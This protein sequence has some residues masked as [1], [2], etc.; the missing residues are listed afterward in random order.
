MEQRGHV[1]LQLHL[2]YQQ[3]HCLLRCDLYKRFYGSHYQATEDLVKYGDKEWIGGLAQY[4]SISKA[5]PMETT[6]PA[7][8]DIWWC[9][10]KYFVLPFPT[11]AVLIL[12]NVDFTQT[13]HER[14]RSILE[15]KNYWKINF[16]EFFPLTLQT[17]PSSTPWQSFL[18]PCLVGCHRNGCGDVQSPGSNLRQWCRWCRRHS[19][20]W[21][22][23]GGDNVTRQ[24]QLIGPWKM[25]Q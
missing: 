13:I 12:S 23:V 6:S 21:S 22:W 15:K 7:L 11:D 8:N 16:L 10:F 9:W 20:Y 14:L 19:D 2:S 17:V 3:F 25:W 24:N 4:L 18:G 1:M 5:L